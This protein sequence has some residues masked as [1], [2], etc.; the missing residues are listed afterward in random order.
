MRSSVRS[1]SIAI[2]RR[3]S[4]MLGSLTYKRG[5]QAGVTKEMLER[6]QFLLSFTDRIPCK[7]NGLESVPLL[8]KSA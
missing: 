3:M 7:S 5:S 8:K 4:K 6:G 2:S 1:V